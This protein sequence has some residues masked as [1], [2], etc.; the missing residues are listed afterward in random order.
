M[1]HKEIQ[2]SITEVARA[3]ERLNR[4][5]EK[6]AD[7]LRQAGDTNGLQEWMKAT[8]AMRDSGNIYLTWAKHYA[9]STDRNAAADESG[10]EE[11]LDE[12]G[13]WSPEQGPGP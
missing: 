2:Q 10:H 7:D 5:F 8:L 13:V 12:G 4:A 9:R 11:F 3:I 1:N 6:R